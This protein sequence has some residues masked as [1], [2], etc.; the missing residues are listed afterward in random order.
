MEFPALVLGASTVV[1]FAFGLLVGS[2]FTRRRMKRQHAA[3]IPDVPR[4]D[5]EDELSVA[6]GRAASGKSPGFA[7]TLGRQSVRRFVHLSRPPQDSNGR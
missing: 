7:E 2:L 5:F 6:V 1:A 3:Y 4:A